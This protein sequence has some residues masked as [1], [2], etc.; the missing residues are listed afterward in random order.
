MNEFWIADGINS[1]NNDLS[2]NIVDF[3]VVKVSKY[4]FI[5]QFPHFE[6]LPYYYHVF[7]KLKLSSKSPRW[8]HSNLKQKTTLKS[9]PANKKYSLILDECF[10][11]IAISIVCNKGQ[12][13]QKYCNVLYNTLQYIWK[14]C[15]YCTI[16]TILTILVWQVL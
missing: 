7:F 2:M 12:T 15:K 14:Y 9:I 13:L 1:K 10:D 5:N 8:S 6:N 3:K 4:W 16:P 11:S